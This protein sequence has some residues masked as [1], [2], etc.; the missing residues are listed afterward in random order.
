MKLFYMWGVWIALTFAV[1][2]PAAEAHD[3]LRAH[4]PFAFVVAGQEFA[5]GDYT[6]HESDSGI[7]WLQGSGKAAIV[8]SY[9]AVPTAPG[10]AAGLLFT[11]SG[12][13]E[14]L[15]GVQSQ[16]LSR[17]LLIQR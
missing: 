3:T 11:K 6:V 7:V 16:D 17:T 15:V 14:Y 10:S 9:P 4:V 8:L 5:A 12:Q 13:K 2:A 1:T